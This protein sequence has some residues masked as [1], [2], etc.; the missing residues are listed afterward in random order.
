MVS[1]SILSFSGFLFSL[2]TLS[3][4]INVL[5]SPGALPTTIGLIFLSSAF[6]DVRIARSESHV[7]ALHGHEDGLK[8]SKDTWFTENLRKECNQLSSLFERHP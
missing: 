6:L 8:E 2:S 7:V 3:A 1:I 4:L 5:T